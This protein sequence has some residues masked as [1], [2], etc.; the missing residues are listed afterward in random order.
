VTATVTRTVTPEP[1]DFEGCSPGFWKNHVDKW[2]AGYAPGDN[3]DT[4]FGTD[5]FHPDITLLD[6]LRL[7]GGG[8]NALTRHAVA[9][10]LNAAHP[11]VDSFIDDPQDVIDLYA[12]AIADDPVIRRIVKNVFADAN[13]EGCP[14]R[15][16]AKR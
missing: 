8:L 5:A 1:D 16:R 11:D 6:G 13:D 9:A 3:L 4:V 14:L 15:G 10:L 2:P 7:R 12:A